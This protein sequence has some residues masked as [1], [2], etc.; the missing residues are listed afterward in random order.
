LTAFILGSSFSSYFAGEDKQ[1]LLVN[2]LLASLIIGLIVNLVLPSIWLS[3][4]RVMQMTGA[5]YYGSSLYWLRM[6]GEFGLSLVVVGAMRRIP[7]WLPIWLLAGE[8]LGR[9]M[10]FTHV[11][12]TSTNIGGIY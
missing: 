11:V 1:P 8:I 12:H 10:I 2:I 3:G 6:L 5:A 7:F 9:I 4:G